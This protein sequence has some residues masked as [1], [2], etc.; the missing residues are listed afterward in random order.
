MGEFSDRVYLM[1]AAG[2]PMRWPKAWTDPAALAL[3]E[4]T[5]IGTLLIDNSDEFESVR[6]RAG[7]VGF[8][9]VHPDAPPDGVTIV[10]GAWPGVK[11]P[12]GGADAEAG[13]TGVPWVDSN[14]WRVRLAKAMHAG[15]AVWIDAAPP[16]DDFL[17]P[18]AY[19]MAAA[20]AAAYGGRWIVSLGDALAADLLAGKPPAA[21]AWKAIADAAAFF[22]RHAPWDAYEPVANVALISDFAGKN[23]FFS[24]ELL[25]LLAR[26][27]LHTAVW[28]KDRAGEVR[29][30]RAVI[31]PDAQPPS[32]ELL[33]KLTAFAAGGGL[34]IGRAGLLPAAKGIALVKMGDPYEVA[35]DAAL[36]ISHRYDLVRC[37]NAGAFGSYVAK[38]PD[39]GRAVAHLLFY[40][41]RGPNEASVRIAGRY[42]EVQACEVTG[43]VRA[44][45]LRQADA[46]EVHLPQVSQ[47][48]ALELIV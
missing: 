19:L 8:A 18:G 47:Y 10:R 11:R 12:R 24:Q 41:D 9:V 17:R 44:E 28:P 22:A 29:G 40:A 27:G 20:D 21:A 15:T 37:W 1:P 45:V 30:V 36:R 7:Q 5:A 42:R 31:Y 6:A 3:L 35:Q 43:P 14:G 39:G 4:G 48:V 13:P 23:E 33:R 38:S 25:N 32:P 16:A 46:I 34:V 26:A 2:T